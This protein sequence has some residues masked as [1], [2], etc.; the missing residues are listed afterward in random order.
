MNKCG[1][2]LMSHHTDVGGMADQLYFY[3][4]K[5]FAKVVHISHPLLPSSATKS[6][7]RSEKLYLNFKLFPALQFLLE[8]IYNYLYFKENGLDKSQY[9]LALCIDPLSYLHVRLLKPF[10]KIKKLIY[11][12]VDYSPR[13]YRNP[14][15]NFIYQTVNRFALSNCDYFFYI[16]GR[17]LSD[18]DPEKR[19][20]DKSFWIKHIHNVSKLRK[21]K[22]LRNSLIFCGHLSVNLD[23]E[24]LFKVLAELKREK[25]PFRFDIYGQGSKLPKLKRQVKKLNLEKTIFFKGSVDH[26]EL[27]QK[28]L[29]RYSIGLAP[30][31]DRSKLASGVAEHTFMGEDL[32][33]K[34]IEYISCGLPVVSTRLYPEFDII[35]KQGFGFL[36]KNSKDWHRAIRELL[37]NR[38]KYRQFSKSALAYAEGYHEEEVLTP[39]IKKITRHIC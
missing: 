5:H 37:T 2:I 10:L 33:T 9:A 35:K 32:S 8:G 34:I 12:N 31:I 25:V 22:K 4:K 38:N 26:K 29:P 14:I 16:T 3:L 6:Y 24:P 30:Y 23:F 18:L 17:F 11:Y 36:V 39:V 19:F 13:R 27:V 28:L 15:L 21:F 20:Q 7:I 1:A